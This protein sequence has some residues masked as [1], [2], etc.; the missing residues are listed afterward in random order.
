MTAAAARPRRRRGSRTPRSPST[1]AVSTSTGT[2]ALVD[3]SH[4]CVGPVDVSRHRRI[5]GRQR[6]VA[7]H[8]ERS[9]V[10]RLPRGTR[11]Q[12]VGHGQPRR[13]PA[14]AYQSTIAGDGAHRR[15]RQ[16]AAQPNSPGWCSRRA[17]TQ[18]PAVEPLLF[19]SR[20]GQRRGVLEV[21]DLEVAHR[22]VR[23][24]ARI[25]T[26]SV[27]RDVHHVTGLGRAP[28]QRRSGVAQVPDH[29]G[30]RRHRTRGQPV[31]QADPGARPREARPSASVPERVGILA[32]RPR[33]PRHAPAVA[34]SP[35]ASPRGRAGRSAGRGRGTRRGGRSRAAASGRT[36]RCPP[37]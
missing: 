36:G 6:A 27:G 19:G 17:P 14:A 34:T 3:R 18:Q 29:V 15:P 30:Q 31:A 13:Q 24:S 20:P 2:V 16:P 26:T 33:Q 10:G 1:T 12:P 37:A 7:D 8:D 35:P 22:R 32:G 5:G 25:A 21:A 11:Q 4:A 28:R 9:R 23:D